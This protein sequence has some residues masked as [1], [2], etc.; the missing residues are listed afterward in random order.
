MPLG[1]HPLPLPPGPPPPQAPDDTLRSRPINRANA[2]PWQRFAFPFCAQPTSPPYDYVPT[3]GTC[4]GRRSAE[5]LAP[6]NCNRYQFQSF[7]ISINIH[8]NRFQ[9]Q[10]LSIS[11]IIQFSNKILNPLVPISEFYFASVHF[12]SKMKSKLA[13][14]VIRGF[15]SSEILAHLHNEFSCF[16]LVIIRM[17][18]HCLKMKVK[19]FPPLILNSQD[20]W[21]VLG[22]G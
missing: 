12:N 9:F 18:F 1:N 16:T 4:K 13:G 2:H 15:P 19:H 11:A 21:L 20:R 3:W 17:Y 8:F 5:L 7:S 10:S 22:F 6:I 14:K